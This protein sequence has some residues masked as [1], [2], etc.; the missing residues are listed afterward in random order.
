MFRK[1]VLISALAALANT[2]GAHDV[3]TTKITWSKEISRL[4]Y[5][6]CASCHAEGSSIPLVTY[7]QS[8]P[9][10]KSMKEEVLERRMP[11]WAAVKGF[12]DFKDDRSLTQEEME[13]ISDWVEGGSP[14]GEPKLL[15][16]APKPTSKATESA[17]LDPAKPDGSSQVDVASGMKLPASEAVLAIRPKDFAK[18][19][20]VQAI[21][22]RPDGTFE[23]LLWI[24]D[25]NPDFARTYYYTAPVSLPAGTSI[26][27]SPADAG[28]LVL[29]AA[30]GKASG[31][32]GLR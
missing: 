6:R 24:Y 1:A 30:H 9:W 16:E 8:R 12:A 27:M 11:P 21:A 19:A 29:F 17:W 20:T 7:E 25:F 13:W 26:I 22:A 28:K 15:P 3:I 31:T 14:E 10:A 5:K 4:V 32:G 2:A 23:P 18:G